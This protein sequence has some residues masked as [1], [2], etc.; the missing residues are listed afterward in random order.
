MIQKRSEIHKSFGKWIK[1]LREAKGDAR[2]YKYTQQSLATDADI[3]RV[4]L[5]RIEAGAGPSAATVTKLAKALGANERE[6]LVR[7]GFSAGFDKDAQ[8]PIALIH[9]QHLSPEAQRVIVDQIEF[10][11]SRE[12]HQAATAPATPDAHRTN[13]KATKKTKKARR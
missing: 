9:F 6:A 8:L 1:S 12:D 10:Y 13:S 2:G 7:A 11:Y 5:A 4:H 3:T